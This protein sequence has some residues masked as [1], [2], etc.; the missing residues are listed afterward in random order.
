MTAVI[1]LSDYRPDA[2]DVAMRDALSAGLDWNRSLRAAQVLA[3]SPNP[4]HR[5]LAEHVRASHS[6]HEAG[7][8]KPVN[9]IHRDKADVR[10]AWREAALETPLQVAK[11]HAP[12]WPQIVAGGVLGAVLLLQISGWGV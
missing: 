7:L 1:R 2:Y 6:L 10:D 11:R 4:T 12:D 5:T 9:P 8:L 3:R